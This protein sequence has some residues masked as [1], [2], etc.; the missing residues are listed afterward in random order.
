MTLG[1]LKMCKNTTYR[2]LTTV[3]AAV[4]FGPSGPAAGEV[5]YAVTSTNLPGYFSTAKSLN[6]S[7]AVAGVGT[8]SAGAS[9]AY[10]RYPDGTLRTFPE[11]AALGF[12]VQTSCSIND[13]AVVAVTAAG[14]V[15]GIFTSRAFVIGPGGVVSVPPL[16]GTYTDAAAINSS[17]HVT[18][19]SDAPFSSL[20]A[21]LFTGSS[22]VDLGQ[23]E[24]PFGTNI[25][26]TA[27][28]DLDHVVGVGDTSSG[29]FSG[30]LWNG[31][32]HNLGT[33]QP[34]GINEAGWACGR[35]II[36]GV[37]RAVVRSPDGSYITLPTLG[38]RSNA[39]LGINNTG[40]VVG[41]SQRA[42]G[43]SGGF[44]WRDGRITDIE[45]LL[46]RAARASD[47]RITSAEAVNDRG[48]ILAFSGFGPLLLTGHEDCPADFN[49]DGGIDGVD[50][51]HFFAS[52]ESGSPLAD[53]NHDGGVD[54]ADIEVFMTVWS[55][56]GC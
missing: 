14:Y 44:L 35:Q 9:L 42:D 3:F 46:D 13:S 22:P 39:A 48:Q 29:G 5:R 36:G 16:S 4:V 8:G 20:R 49:R 11:L 10:V 23:I 27:M 6:V 28:N 18:G 40:D 33:F 55:N 26:A 2:T 51:H 7:G 38:G 34:T 24:P 53:V 54:G 41:S 15:G 12:E 56:G 31:T 50:V 1:V 45:T 47:W 25:R 52:W 21:Y 30:F 17:G 43:S 32:M 19:R 37:L